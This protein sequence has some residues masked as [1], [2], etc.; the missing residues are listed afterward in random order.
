MF[1]LQLSQY[2]LLKRGCRIYSCLLCHRLMIELWVYFWTI[3]SV[4]LMHMSILCLCHDVLIIVALKCSLKSG[5]FIASAM[6][7]FSLR[8]ALEMLGLFDSL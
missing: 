5:R 8:I 6:S 4:P 2:D 7:F 3:C 1:W